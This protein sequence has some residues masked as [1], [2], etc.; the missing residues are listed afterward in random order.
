VGQV[1]SA[2]S[3]LSL[4]ASRAA[5]ERHAWPELA[6]YDCFAC[7][8]DLNGGLQ[9]Q[10]R[11]P[12]DA[13]GRLRWSSWYVAMLPRALAGEQG[14]ADIPSTMARLNDLLGTAQPNRRDV[15]E[16]ARAA[17]RRLRPWPERLERASGYDAASLRARF[18]ETATQDQRLAYRGWDEAT[19][20]CLALA[21][22][23]EAY[24]QTSN[25][26]SA[27]FRRKHEAVQ[28][29]ESLLAF[30]AGY[31]SPKND[32]ADL[33]FDRRLGDLLKKLSD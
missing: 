28:G 25:E 27:Q 21:A 4:L 2:E 9:R 22:L 1:A 19:Q 11:I 33:S 10:E 15:A 8:H 13:A 6:E 32:P 5:D 16:Q 31:D 26:A 17:V 12:G 20:F 29:L 23:D 3:A 18:L 24:R 30:P 14:G 7:H